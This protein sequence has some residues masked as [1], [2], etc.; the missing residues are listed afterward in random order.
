M[1]LGIALYFT[2]RMQLAALV[3]YMPMPVLGGYLAFIGLYCGEAGISLMTGNPLTKLSDYAHIFDHTHRE[4][5]AP[6]LLALPGVLLGLALMQIVGRF[7]H[8]AVLPCCLLAIPVSFYIVMYAGGWDLDDARS[9]G[10][11]EGGVANHTVG[12]GGVQPKS[13]GSSGENEFYYGWLHYYFSGE[14][15]WYAI[16]P[17]FST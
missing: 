16:G 8:V 15:Q 11:V 7:R 17:Q 12:H 3:Q 9:A 2:G 5:I 4:Q 10:W 1:L 6:A 14:I 13:G